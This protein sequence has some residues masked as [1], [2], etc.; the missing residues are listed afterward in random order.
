M[1]CRFVALILQ[2]IIVSMA[3]NSAYAACDVSDIIGSLLRPTP[4]ADI[5]YS[6][7]P[8][9]EPF[10][11]EYS[12][13]ASA[14]AWNKIAGTCFPLTPIDTGGDVYIGWITSADQWDDYPVAADAAAFTL[15]YSMIY[16]NLVF[17]GASDWESSCSDCIG[18]PSSQR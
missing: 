12:V 10:L 4:L 2:L 15:D 14:A 17:Y 7:V 9:D 16:L 5:T 18:P 1:K 6:Y 11:S 13:N 3:Y 8:D